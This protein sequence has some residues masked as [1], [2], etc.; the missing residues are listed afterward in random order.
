VKIHVKEQPEE[1]KRFGAPWTPT[2]LIM[3]P[4]GIER[5]RIEGFLPVEDFLAQ[6]Q[7]GLAKIEFQRQNF[8]AAEKLFRS[9]YEKFPSASAAAEAMYWAGVAK[10]KASNSGQDLTETGKMLSEKYPDSE[11]ARKGS[12]WIH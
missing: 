3:D 7:L 10:Y 6:L 5:H 11:W 9:V 1:F 2:Q 12:V 8:P 4:D